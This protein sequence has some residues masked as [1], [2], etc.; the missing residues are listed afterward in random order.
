MRAIKLRRNLFSS[1]FFVLNIIMS[2]SVLR[3]ATYYVSPIGNDSGAGSL[4]A[5]WLTIQKAADSV[6]AGD[7]VIVRAGIY[8]ERARVAVS[9]TSA[10][11]IEFKAEGKAVTRG[12]RIDGNDVRL[13]GFHFDYLALNETA[14]AYNYAVEMKG[15]RNQLRNSR[16]TAPSITRGGA[17]LVAGTYGVIAH[18]EV[19]RWPIGTIVAITG[20]HNVA[21]HNVIHDCS[22]I[23]AFRVLG[24]ENIIQNNTVVD[25]HDGPLANHIDFIQTF[26]QN[27]D[28]SYGNIIRHNFIK[29]V[30]GQ[31]GQ[32]S[33]CCGKDFNGSNKLGCRCSEMPEVNGEV[34]SMTANTITDS[35]RNWLQGE[36]GPNHWK[37]AVV[38]FV[39]GAAKGKIFLITGNTKTTLTVSQTNDLPAD[40]VAE[41]VKVSDPF[42]IRMRVGWWTVE[43]NVFMDALQISNNLPHMTFIGNTFINTPGVTTGAG[44]NRGRS[45]HNEFKNNVHIHDRGATQLYGPPDYMKPLFKADYNYTTLGPPVYAKKQDNRCTEE[46]V[47][48]YFCEEK[49]GKHGINGGD[50]LFQDFN[51]PLGKDG[52]A[53]TDDDGLKPMA[54]SRLCGSGENGADIGAYPC[55]TGPSAP[56]VLRHPMSQTV[57]VGMQARLTVTATGSPSPTFGWQKNGVPLSNS[58]RISGATSSTL[59]IEDVE[60]G[61]AGVYRCVVTNAVGSSTSNDSTLT[62]IVMPPSV[63]TQPVNRTT[64]V[65]MSATFSVKAAGSPTLEYQWS[66]NGVP[67]TGATNATY[68]KS[69]VAMTDSGKKY[70]CTIS[71]SAGS[72]TSEP[73]TLTVTPEAVAP[74]ILNHPFDQTVEAGDSAIFVVEA[75]G[76]PDPE[77][78]WFKNGKAIGGETANSL[79]ILNAYTADNGDVFYCRVSNIAGSLK[80]QEAKLVV[81]AANQEQESSS[82]QTTFLPFNKVLNYSTEKVMTVRYRASQDSHSIKILDRRGRDIK[83]LLPRPLSDGAYEADW[84]ARNTS[85]AL[86]A[87]GGYI[88]LLDDQGTTEKKSIIFI[89]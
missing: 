23:D 43:N 62:V 70:S 44:A 61:D 40:L 12:F 86:V 24:N 8:R 30:A 83:R 26:G 1:F 78:Q 17:I 2:V 4:G 65:G 27:G 55:N 22:D 47:S 31:I 36:W 38:S 11:P 5:P 33:Q 71:N 16:F 84:D 51:N 85:G 42:E 63:V 25:I 3:A 81:Q 74:T 77:Y 48:F 21:E 64:V 6:R 88:L 76:S 56:R 18:N 9:G 19:T 59:V 13:D 75:Q 66:E 54:G 46:Y 41:G 39:E 35:A 37:G 68:T 20:H 69:A 58:T 80:S 53:F 49:L 28:S 67:I 87:S 82:R 89:K 52:I 60:T 34:T 15:N 32:L 73:G 10:Q 45:F 14:L 72:V 57:G 7:T 79:S 29:N 50:P